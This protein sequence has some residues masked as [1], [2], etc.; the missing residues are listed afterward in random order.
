MFEDQQLCLTAFEISEYWSRVGKLVEGE[1]IGAPSMHHLPPWYELCSEL[2]WTYHKVGGGYFSNENFGFRGVYRIVALASEED[3]WQPAILNRVCGHDATGTL[4]IGEA[5]N[6]SARLNQLR[7]T[8]QNRR[9]RSH[10]AMQMLRSI[11]RLKYPVDKLGVAILFT[12]CFPRIV[13]R[14]LLESYIISFGDM[15]PLN[16]RL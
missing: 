8:A 9:E 10:G 12:R 11:T 14:H 7:R 3:L 4:Y 5:G 13:E 15:P 2:E 16:Y 6:I 1:V